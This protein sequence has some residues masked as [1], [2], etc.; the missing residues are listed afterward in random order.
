MGSSAELEKLGIGRLTNNKTMQKEIANVISTLSQ[1]TPVHRIIY[2]S[3]RQITHRSG[4][5][6]SII[7]LP[8]EF[9]EAIEHFISNIAFLTL[10][11]KRRVSLQLSA[12]VLKRSN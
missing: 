4:K 3:N 7:M 2:A 10:S 8:T 6:T 5:S 11:N 12:P 9:F 1:T